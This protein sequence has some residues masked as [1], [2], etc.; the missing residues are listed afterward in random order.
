MQVDALGA[1][2]VGRQVLAVTDFM[3]AYLPRD[4]QTIS[5]FW[6]KLVWQ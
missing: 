1:V 5:V 3:E 4:A 6:I 2:T